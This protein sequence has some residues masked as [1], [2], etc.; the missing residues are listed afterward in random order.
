VKKERPGL[1]RYLE[2][3]L[4]RSQGRGAERHFDCP[5][6]IDRVG[7][8]SSGKKLDINIAKGLASC[9]RC[10]W[11][12]NLERLFRS[13]NGGALTMEAGALVYGETRAV[14]PQDL[15]DTVARGLHSVIPENVLLTEPLPQGT[16]RIAD[17][18]NASRARRGWKYFVEERGI[19]PELLEKYHVGYCP[20][21][22]FANRLIFPVY[23]G[24]SQIY[25]TSRYCGDHKIKA[26]NPD[27][28]E[29]HLSKT[30]VIWNYDGLVGKEIIAITEGVMSGMAFE[31]AGALL[32]KDISPAQIRLIVALVPL[33]LEEV[34]VALD[35]DA[36][37]YAEKIY[38]ALQDKVPRCSVLYLDHGDPHDRRADLPELLKDR[39]VPSLRTRVLSRFIKSK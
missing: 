25:F 26:R 21:G 27:W 29:G 10:G 38:F 15:K 28:R 13:M 11:G 33:G 35:P 34:I 36:G 17:P 3:V 4:G 37:R 6:C 31:D 24:G 23:Q 2:Q 30:D 1:M 16:L 12:G 7:S 22:E 9:Y 14:S 19:M 39:Q 5:F 32:G 18:A 8:E 20:D